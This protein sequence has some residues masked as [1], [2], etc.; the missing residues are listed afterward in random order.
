MPIGKLDI[1][2]TL[3]SAGVTRGVKQASKEINAF[4]VAVGTAIGNLAAD[5]IIKFGAAASEAFTIGLDRMEAFNNAA[6]RL[7]QGMAGG[8]NMKALSD[9]LNDLG[10]DTTAAQDIVETFANTVGNMLAGKLKGGAKSLKALGVSVVDAS[11]QVRPLSAIMQDT[12]NRINLIPSAA[13]RATTAAK[14][15]G[16]E[17]KE[18]AGI[19]NTVPGAIAASTSANAQ[20]A[21]EWQQFAGN[22]ETIGDSL[23][24]FF[25]RDLPNMILPF[26]NDL[27]DTIKQAWPDIVAVFNA[28]VAGLA[29]PI[30]TFKAAMVNLGSQVDGLVNQFGGWSTVAGVV[31]GAVAAMIEAISQLI[32]WFGNL[33]MIAVDA[34]NA[35]ANAFGAIGAFGS[36]DAVRGWEMVG[37][38]I[39]NGSDSLEH[40]K[41]VIN[42]APA[43]AAVGNAY[44]DAF[45]KMKTAV[46]GV[47]TANQTAS[48]QTRQAWGA[49][50][51]TIQSVGVMQDKLG[52]FWTGGGGKGG[53]GGKS[54]A[55]GA[56]E[57][58]T[59][60][61]ALA[62]T[63]NEGVNPMIVYNEQMAI[64]NAAVAQGK[65][66]AEHMAIA[67]KLAA[68]KAKAAAEAI[69][70]SKGPM[71]DF[72]EGFKQWGSSVAS[73]LA[74]AIV[75]GENL[76][77]VFQS[78]IKALI[79]MALEMLVLKPLMESLTGMFGGGKGGFS[80]P[81]PGVGAAAAPAADTMRALPRVG[82][83]SGGRNAS[84]GSASGGNVSMGNM[85]INIGTGG[86]DGVTGDNQ[87][88]RAFGKRLSEVVQSEI[89]R[90]SRPGGLL[91]GG[92][93]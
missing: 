76:E 39:K 79:K 57:F 93:R 4:G 66:S 87:R 91:W 21:A 8:E 19:L 29:G 63:I 3:D 23:T 15:F 43:E 56:Q 34:A 14:I 22:I 72:Q 84:T 80:I 71:A 26:F 33:I 86:G 18:M 41:Q 47:A 36:G 55:K 35:V 68:D 42:T 37:S 82:A 12:V 74:D 64:F 67:Q 70:A 31:A 40:L 69:G 38:A 5:A 48:N 77:D 7:G 24:Q 13:Q 81:I 25:Q 32:T 11:G 89:V 62:K 6:N 54:P 16:T 28:G 2:M 59:A 49:T 46:D 45:N 60:V 73:S 50:I 83:T 90:Q 88:S 10:A 27:V 53:G 52:D 20:A 51:P 30:D 75:E 85:T 92:A 61:D 9:G 44:I 1:A 58:Q 78:L 65:V 17:T